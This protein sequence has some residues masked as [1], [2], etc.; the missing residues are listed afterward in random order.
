MK[1]RKMLKKFA[2]FLVFLAATIIFATIGLAK[3][4]E[5]LNESLMRKIARGEKDD[6]SGLTYPI[7]FKF[8]LGVK[9]G[10]TIFILLRGHVVLPNPG[11]RPYMTFL[12]V[13]SQVCH[14][15]WTLPAVALTF[16]EPS[17]SLRLQTP[18]RGDA[19]AF[20]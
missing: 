3:D 1:D 11:T 13:N 19:L 17:A 15:G 12:F 7:H 18:P 8:V 4:S 6:V 9:D 10:G 14:Q 20:G 2:I 16:S 5:T